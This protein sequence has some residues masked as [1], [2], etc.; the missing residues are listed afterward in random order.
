MFIVATEKEIDSAECVYTYIHT[1]ICVYNHFPPKGPDPWDLFSIW[2]DK[3][4]TKTQGF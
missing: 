2:T 4:K 3:G 1:C